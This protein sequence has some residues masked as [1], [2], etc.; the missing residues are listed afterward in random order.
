ME[1][2]FQSRLIRTLENEILRG[3]FVLKNDPTFRQGVPDLV[4]LYGTNWA[5]LESKDSARSPYRPNQ[6]YYLDLFNQM[7]YA[8]TIYPGNEKEIF[9]ALQRTLKP[10]GRPRLIKP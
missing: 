4:I 7:S 3:C 2:K 1:S 6:E 10:Q 8:A 5:M 9:D